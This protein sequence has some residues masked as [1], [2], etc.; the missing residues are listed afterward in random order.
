MENTYIFYSF[1]S[2]FPFLHIQYTIFV[3]IENLGNHDFVASNVAITIEVIRF[4]GDISLTTPLKQ[5]CTC[6]NCLG[7]CP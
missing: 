1:V 5:V 7:N 4:V 2:F 3:F 6:L